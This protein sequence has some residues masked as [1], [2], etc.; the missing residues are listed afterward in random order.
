MA[1]SKSITTK[2]LMIP[3]GALIGGAIFYAIS[4]GAGASKTAL[5]L[6][7]IAGAAAGA[8]AGSRK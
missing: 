6:L 7:T 5:T 2:K 8:Y 4:K 1:E 3:L